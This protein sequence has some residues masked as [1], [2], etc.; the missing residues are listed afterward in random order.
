MKISYQL[1][2]AVFSLDG[3][4]CRRHVAA[5]ELELFSTVRQT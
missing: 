4:E 3:R 5:V 2:E 1:Q